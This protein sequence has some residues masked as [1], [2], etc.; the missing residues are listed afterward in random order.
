[1]ITPDNIFRH[2]L[3]GLH[4]V[5]VNA[6]NSQMIGISGT[7][8]DETK[9]MLILDTKSGT[10]MIPKNTSKWRFDVAGRHI[11]INGEQITKRSAERLMI[12]V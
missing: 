3:V 5:I 10:K 6:T 11:H 12:K 1:M 2:E 9:S 7:V 8:I 4:A